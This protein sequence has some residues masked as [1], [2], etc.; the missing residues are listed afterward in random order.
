MTKEM[1]VIF[2]LVV[3]LIVFLVTYI[4]DLI[5][6]KKKKQK[7]IGEIQYLTSKFKLDSNKINYK[8]VSLVIALLNSFIISTVTLVISLVNT[9]MTLQLVIG[10]VLLFA[11]IYSVYEIYGRILI[12]KGYK[13]KVGK[14]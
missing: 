6:I 4:I 2:Y 11:L 8:R 12:K 7:K 10:F 9:N 1:Y 3:Y 5:K 13:K 14:K